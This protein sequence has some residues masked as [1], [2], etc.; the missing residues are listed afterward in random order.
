MVTHA[1]ITKKLKMA[2]VKSGIHVSTFVHGI[3]NFL[4]MIATKFQRL[5]P[6]LFLGLF[7]TEWLVGILSDVGY[8]VNQRWRPLTGSWY[9]I[10]YISARAYD[11]N[12]MWTAIPTFLRSSNSVELVPILSGL[13]GSQIFKMAAVKPKV[14]VSQLV[15][16][17]NRNS[18]GTHHV[19][20]DGQLNGTRRM[21]F[22]VSGSRKSKMAAV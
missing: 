5:Y 17:M 4:Y 19:F 22:D 3:S 18:K 13:N 9:E 14:H 16:M 11:S 7:N 12:Q 1:D 2:A 8:V 10:T 15:D 6:C 20:E 21:L